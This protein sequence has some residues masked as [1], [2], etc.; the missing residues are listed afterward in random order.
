MSEL[1]SRFLMEKNQ[2]PPTYQEIRCH[3]IF[4]VK[5]EDFRRNQRFVAGGH[6]PYTPHAITYASGVSR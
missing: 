1:H 5:T 6:T 3:V 4:D 2:P